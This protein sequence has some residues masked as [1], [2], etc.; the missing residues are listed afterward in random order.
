VAQV[1][2]VVTNFNAPRYAQQV[3]AFDAAVKAA[4]EF[5]NR[6]CNGLSTWDQSVAGLSL[7]CFAFGMPEQTL[8]VGGETISAGRGGIWLRDAVPERPERLQACFARVGRVRAL[9]VTPPADAAP[10]VVARHF[11][12]LLG[13]EMGTRA[14]TSAPVYGLRWHL[15]EVRGK[16]VEVVA[17]DMCDE[18]DHW[19]EPGLIQKFDGRFSLEMIRSGHI[20][21][22][23]DGAPPKRGWIMLPDERSR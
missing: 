13:W 10:G 23:M 3:G 19:P 5:I 15:Y 9:S 6:H 7:G 2:S 4:D 20:R 14:D 11:V 18:T 1:V 8:I 12:E 16:K 21:W 22:H 17:S